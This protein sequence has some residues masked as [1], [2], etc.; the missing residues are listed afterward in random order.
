MGSYVNRVDYKG[1]TLID[2]SDTTAEE[3]DVAEGHVFYKSSGARALGT[4][5]GSSVKEILS[6]TTAGW[7]ADPGLVSQIDILYV[8]TDHFENE[9]NGET[10]YSPGYKI[11]DG[12]AY[13]I[14]LP[15]TSL[16]FELH[17]AD[18]VRHITAEER[19]FWNNKNRGYV[20]DG[21]ETLYL[22]VH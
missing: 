3:E 11:G 12:N 2:I 15:F 5:S 8:Y 16:P 22:T 14:D 10:V 13:V 20:V 6:D 4:G 1:K 17:I 18:D 7:N 21:E 9:V 19:T